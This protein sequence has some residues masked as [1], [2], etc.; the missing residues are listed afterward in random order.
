MI[1]TARPKAIQVQRA[2]SWTPWIQI[3]VGSMSNPGWVTNAIVI[4]GTAY[5]TFAM[6]LAS[7][8]GSLRKGEAVK[9]VP[10]EGRLSKSLWLNLALVGVCLAFC[11]GAICL[12]WIPIAIH[13]SDRRSRVFVTTGLVLF[14]GGAL[15]VVWARRVLGRMWGISTSREVKLL[16]DHRLIMTGPYSVVRHPMYLGWWIAALGLLLIYRTWILAALLILSILVFARRARLEEKTLA[17]RLGEEWRSYV[18]RTR[19]L[20]PLVF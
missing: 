7:W 1:Q 10:G 9:L 4:A 12:L 11:A 18:A 3:E 13:S 5:L 8:F 6:A 17:A 16:P 20:L 2:G 15:L 19:S 14:V